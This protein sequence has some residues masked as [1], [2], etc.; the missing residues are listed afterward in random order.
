MCINM[1][2]NEYIHK[3]YA[4]F[5]AMNA[6]IR[7]GAPVEP[8]EWNPET[9]REAYGEIRDYTK[10]YEMF[11]AD[12][13]ANGPIFFIRAL[14]DKVDRQELTAQDVADAWLNYTRENIGMFWWGG[15]GVST[16]HTSYNN[17]LKG[18]QAPESGSKEIN[19]QT[20]AEQVGGQ[21]F[22]D[23][24][25]W[26][27]PNDIK[28]A[29]QYA[30]IAAS[31][32]H[33]G[34]GL[35][36]ARF[37]A[38][39]VSSAF[40]REDIKDVIQDG[41]SVIPKDSLYAKL[42]EAV[43][44]FHEENPNDYMACRNYLEAEWGY[45]KYPGVCHIIPN[46]GVCV[47]SLVY[48]NGDIARTIEIATMCGWDTDSN[49][50]NV[51]SIVGT[52]SGIENFP[53]NYRR[54]INDTIAASSVSGYLNIL[55]VPTFVKEVALLSYEVNGVEP[56]SQLVDS[57]R[58]EE[59]YFDFTLRGSTHGFHAQPDYKV[60]FNHRDIQGFQSDGVLEIYLDRFVEG[61]QCKVFYKTFYQRYEFND[62]KYKPTFAPKAY[63]G[64]N[65]SMKLYLDQ[66]RGKDVFITPYVLDAFTK[67]PV[68]LMKQKLENKT[69][70]DISFT[71]PDVQGALIK[72]VG[73]FIESPSPRDFRTFGKL[74]LDEFC[75]SGPSSY[76]IDLSKQ[77]VEFMSVTPFAHHNGEWN[78]LN[79]SMHGMASDNKAAKSFTGH[80]YERDYEFTS[81]FIPLSGD[82]H[83]LVFCAEGVMKHFE[84]GFDG[85]GKVILNKVD[86]GDKVLQEA[87]FDWKLNHSY[88]FKVRSN[89]GK[90]KFY[91]D[92]EKIIDYKHKE[93][94]RGMI[95]VSLGKGAEATF[96]EFKVTE[97]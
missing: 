16:E 57:F 46:A 72:E 83:K 65:V 21:I 31:V 89:N 22:V 86:F 77:N 49:A 24:W 96:Y 93:Q 27:F 78:L 6:G 94:M 41:L 14:I 51:G 23:T 26:L 59:V 45:D 33:D 44:A 38:A 73:F 5:L 63:S 53:K 71:I 61:E 80:Y 90:I 70:N 74:L 30:E 66:V 68:K 64:Q 17:L 2:N 76:T 56:P 18:I 91:I 75:I 12:D 7:L 52:L 47:L 43:L 3:V 1:M 55:D 60:V 58:E 82:K 40:Q 32:S 28:K 62:E 48:G 9:I 85:T 13:D 67:Q 50:G 4:G 87:N 84:I 37:I 88:E 19:G 39:C 97:L 35:V 79:G 20:M 95:G 42:V 69:W 29:A 34:E 15:V 25:G 36:G 92:G 54:P 8:T 81:K 10:R 11:S